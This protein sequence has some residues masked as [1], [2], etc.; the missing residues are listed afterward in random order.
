MMDATNQAT[1]SQKT[2]ANSVREPKPNRHQRRAQ[3]KIQK[4]KSKAEARTSS[5]RKQY[6][7]QLQAFL[8]N[9]GKLSQQEADQAFKIALK[10]IFKD[11]V[12]TQADFDKAVTLSIKHA[13]EIVKGNK[14]A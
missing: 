1:N 13:R 11:Q 12:K 2:D 14:E 5:L 10:K 9:P 3:A 6:F 8:D 4:T 7:K